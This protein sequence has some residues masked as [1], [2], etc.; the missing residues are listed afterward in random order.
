M[1]VGCGPAG[2]RRGGLCC[3][4]TGVLGVVALTLLSLVEV[5]NPTLVFESPGVE[6]SG[7]G[8]ISQISPRVNVKARMTPCVSY[9]DPTSL[10]LFD[11]TL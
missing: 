9:V 6:H 10:F 4:L 2:Q 8:H 5:S 11:E 7:C 3:S 1:I